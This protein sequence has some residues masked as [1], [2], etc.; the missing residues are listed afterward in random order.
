MRRLVLFAFALLVLAAG[1]AAAE[2]PFTVSGIGVD[3]SAASAAVAQTI[4]INSGRPKA[5]SVLVRRLTKEA[6]WPK[7]LTV[8]D[9]TLQRMIRGYTVQDERR[10]TTRFVANITYV[11]N[12]DAVRRLFR[13]DNVAY[14]DTSMPPVLVVPM[15]PG[16]AANGAWTG[17]MA[18][19]RSAAPIVLP[20]GD[21]L[22]ASELD[23]IKFDTVSWQDLQPVAQRQHAGEAYL[24]LAIP[25]KNQITVKLRR[26]GPGASPPI[27]DVV[28]PVAANEPAPQAYAAAADATAAAIA[29]AWKL[30]AAI[31]FSQRSKL[32]AE[33]A[34]QSP[35]SWGALL[36]KLGTVPVV[37]DVTIVGMDAGEARVA[38]TYAGSADQLHDMLTG[39][40]LDLSQRDGRWW[41]SDTSS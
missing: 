26:V 32:T 7:L 15:A 6:D 29:N 33:V 38:L 35:Q 27:P 24:A 22:D 5:W 2:D 4:A 1:P 14:V 11:F 19:R 34:I 37:T 12:P 3:A 41:L 18:A 10:S 39:A 13:A 25:A 8:D 16:Y 28:V 23:G 20:V 31:D 40:N 9:L 17:L 30:R 21:G 36:Q